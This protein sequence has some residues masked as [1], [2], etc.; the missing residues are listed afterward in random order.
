M[1]IGVEAGIFSA[2]KKNSV[3]NFGKIKNSFY[4]SCYKY[5]SSQLVQKEFLIFLKLKTLFF[6]LRI[7]F[8]YF[9]VFS[10]E[11]VDFMLK[12]PFTLSAMKRQP[13]IL[14]RQMSPFQKA[15]TQGYNMISQ[16]KLSEINPRFP[17]QPKQHQNA[18]QKSASHPA[19]K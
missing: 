7:I 9:S 15:E 13:P 1:K 18:Y 16:R 19:G 4:T 12:S 11:K 6:F 14:K 10:I 5:Y 2:V 17:G 3:R 8:G